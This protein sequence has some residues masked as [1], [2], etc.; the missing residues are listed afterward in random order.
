APA[1]HVSELLAV[2]TELEARRGF[3]HL[4]HIAQDELAVLPPV[5]LGIGP[6]RLGDDKAIAEIARKENRLAV[7][8]ENRIG[9]LVRRAR[10]LLRL[11]QL[12]VH[13]PE[14]TPRDESDLQAV[15]RE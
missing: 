13:D 2:G 11:A 4:K 12:R 3:I 6:V 14:I 9:F 8:R 1:A 7:R 15:L 10:H 5:L